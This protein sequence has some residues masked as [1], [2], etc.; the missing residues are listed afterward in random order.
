[1]IGDSG[2]Y[3]AGASG[4]KLGRWFDTPLVPSFS[5][6]PLLDTMHRAGWSPYADFGPGLPVVIA[7][8]ALV[9][10]LMTAAVVV[11]VLSMGLLAWGIMIGPWSPRRPSELWLR[12]LMAI[13]VSCWPIV[14]FTSTGV[15]SEPLFCAALVWLCVLLARVTSPRT[16]QLVGLGVLVMFLGTLRFVGPVVAVVAAVL[17]VQRGVSKRRAAIW[18]ALTAFVP[19]ATTVVATQGTGAR[20]VAF[21]RL[22]ETDVFFAARGIGGWFE[23][24]FG[25]QT[26][27][28]FRLD[29][30]PTVVDWLIVA[31]SA[32][33]A[34]MVVWHWTR[35]LR[36]RTWFPLHPPLILG[37]ALVL[38]VLPSMLFIDAVVKLENRL[39][40]PTGILI[41]CAGGWALAQL[42]HVGVA[43]SAAIA[44]TIVA[45]HPWNWMDRQ[46][47]PSSTRL[48]D[49]VDTLVVDRN[50]AYVL[51]TNAD[52]VWWISGVPA[53][54][55]PDGYHELSDRT[56]DVV[57]IMTAMPCSLSDTRGAIVVETAFVPSKVAEHLAAD[58]AA[59]RYDM[60]D[61]AGIAVYTPTGSNC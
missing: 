1:M 23:A 60:V 36:R 28:L 37:V 44:W 33:A 50:I 57:P 59:G 21:H 43:T 8:L 42:D 14:R 61:S 27:T 55:L 51:T 45:T 35:S 11:N 20:V 52:L 38:A 7:V 41:L 13:A 18:G 54:Y 25:D 6:L 30:A 47:P 24:G 58:T 49:T 22:D 26:R 56:Y 2:S 5:E 12:S 46:D 48:T 15:L 53:R 9:M 19:L 34:L 40:M 16:P 3:L 4:L 31:A 10:P 39:V 32:S 17:L 29:Y